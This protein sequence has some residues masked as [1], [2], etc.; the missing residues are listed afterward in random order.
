MRRNQRRSARMT[1]VLIVALLCLVAQWFTTGQACVVPSLSTPTNV[2]VPG[3]VTPAAV[4]VADFNFGGRPDLAVADPENHRIFIMRG[5]GF[6]GFTL[7]SDHAVPRLRLDHDP[8]IVGDFNNDGFSDVAAGGGLLLN[9]GSGSFG[10]ASLLPV[11][12]ATGLGAVSSV[13]FNRD[14][15]LD[16]AITV[17]SNL[18]PP[19]AARVSVLLGNG[20]GGFGPPID[21]DLSAGD[22]EPV[23]IAVDDFDLDGKADVAVS[24][25]TNQTSSEYSILLGSGAGSL[26]TARPLGGRG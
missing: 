18:N 2:L 14:G 9:N 5:D 20:A 23:S 16:L 12:G 11:R 1:A 17:S 19:V 15:N 10:A 21:S 13:D 6:G 25:I 7:S 26:S 22:K 24:S 3:S 8:I 4:A